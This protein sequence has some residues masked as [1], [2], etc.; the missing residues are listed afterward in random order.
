MEHLGTFSCSET[1]GGGE[2]NKM[3]RKIPNLEYTG[4]YE[5]KEY[6][7]EKFN[8]KDFLKMPMLLNI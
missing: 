2:R 3:G 6:N 8:T 1:C 5:E 4:K 7:N